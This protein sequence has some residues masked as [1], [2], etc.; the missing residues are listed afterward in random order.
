MCPSWVRAHN[1]LRSPP[2]RR[3]AGFSQDRFEMVHGAFRAVNSLAPH[4]RI[5]HASEHA[6]AQLASIP[7]SLPWARDRSGDMKILRRVASLAACM[8]PALAAGGCG[9]DDSS[10]ASWECWLGSNNGP[11]EITYCSCYRSNLEPYEGSP[12]VGRNCSES[13]DP[14][15]LC[16]AMNDPAHS[17]AG[18]TCYY[19]VTGSSNAD[20]INESNCGAD[21]RIVDSC[22]PP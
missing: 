17:Q 18:C 21:A 8:V 20:V 1:I 13:A 11:T 6:V 19:E 4:P 12:P 5:R 22:P 15:F 2:S 3:L 16:C 14:Q 7:S 9:D 10:S